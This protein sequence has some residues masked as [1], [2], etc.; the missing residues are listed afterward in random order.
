MLAGPHVDTGLT[1]WAVLTQPPPLATS[2]HQEQFRP[3]A[4]ESCVQALQLVNWLQ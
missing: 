4:L 3:T 1:H 2:L